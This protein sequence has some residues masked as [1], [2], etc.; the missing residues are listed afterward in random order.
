MD[1]ATAGW[2]PHNDHGFLG[3]VGPVWQ[4]QGE[5]GPELAF[6]AAAKHENLRG[7]V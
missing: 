3:L 6:E 2:V 1:F 4:R 5:E 7:V